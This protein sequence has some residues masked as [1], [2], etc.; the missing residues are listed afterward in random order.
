MK[1]TV[2]I[3]NKSYKEEFDRWYAAFYK[4]QMWKKGDKTTRR[5]LEGKKKPT[6]T[7]E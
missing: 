7:K 1:V 6:S 4:L 2:T 3:G 5:F